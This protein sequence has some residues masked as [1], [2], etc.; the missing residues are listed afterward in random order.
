MAQLFN[1]LSGELNVNIRTLTLKR[2][3][4]SKKL[5][6]IGVMRIERKPEKNLLLFASLLNRNNQFFDCIATCDEKWIL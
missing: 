3:E 2:I 6:K 1:E 5:E 4:E